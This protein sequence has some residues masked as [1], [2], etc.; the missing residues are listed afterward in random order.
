VRRVAWHPTA[1]RCA[2]G[3]WRF[4]SR[5]IGTFRTEKRGLSACLG[6]EVVGA[7]RPSYFCVCQLTRAF[8]KSATR[9]DTSTLFDEELDLHLPA[10]AE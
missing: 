4:V 9:F 1:E 7:G 5:M 8:R 6:S 10:P 2:V 3:R